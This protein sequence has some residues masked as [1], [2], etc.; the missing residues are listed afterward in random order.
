MNKTISIA[1]SHL[2]Q[3]C[4]SSLLLLCII[5]LIAC[6]L[7]SCS[8][9]YVLNSATC[10]CDLADICAADNPCVNDGTCTLETPPDQYS[11]NCPNSFEEN[12]NCSG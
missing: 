11:C 8:D 9:G 1:V 4:K 10:N 12:S 7:S 2:Q 5:V 6:G 3:C